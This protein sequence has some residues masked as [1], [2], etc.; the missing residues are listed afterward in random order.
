MEIWVVE[1][2]GYDG[3]GVVQNAGYFLTPE[4]AQEWCDTNSDTGCS[5]MSLQP[6]KE[7]E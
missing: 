4:A 3:G 5:I 6:H 1:W 7:N 2:Y